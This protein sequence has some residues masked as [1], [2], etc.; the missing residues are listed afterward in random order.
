MNKSRRILNILRKLIELDLY[1]TDLIAILTIL[2][3]LSQYKQ[4]VLE[5]VFLKFEF[6]LVN[7]LNNFNPP[8]AQGSAKILANCLS[9]DEDIDQSFINAGILSTFEE[10]FNKQKLKEYSKLREKVTFMIGNLL[11]S[12]NSICTRVYHSSL[13]ISCMKQLAE[14]HNEIVQ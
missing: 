13:I 6:P 12:S 5:M 2:M 14:E 10:L 11:C 4:A 3:N 7:E 8:V 1:E 9:M